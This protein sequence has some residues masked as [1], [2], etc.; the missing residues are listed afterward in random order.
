[1]ASAI[2]SARVW[3][4]QR[5]KAMS[6][7]PGRHPLGHHLHADAAVDDARPGG[8]GASNVSTSAMAPSAGQ[9]A[10]SASWLA[11]DFPPPRRTA[12]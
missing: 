11:G 4:A 6:S 8:G 9:S 3:R 10:A 5:M 2:I 7:S 12:P 1:M